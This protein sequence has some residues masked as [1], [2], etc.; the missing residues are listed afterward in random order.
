MAQIEL[1]IDLGGPM[2]KAMIAG[3]ADIVDAMPTYRYAVILE[4]LKRDALSRVLIAEAI[5][6]RGLLERAIDEHNQVAMDS[7]LMPEGSYSEKS[8]DDIAMLVINELKD[9]PGGRAEV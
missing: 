2:R 6:E 5:G 8:W 3:I 7:G 9:S 4:L 1:D